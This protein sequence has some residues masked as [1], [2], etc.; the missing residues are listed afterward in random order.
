MGRIIGRQADC[1]SIPGNDANAEASHPPRKLRG[2]I[3]PRLEGNLIA[4]PAENL[5]DTARRLNQ[6]VSSQKPLSMGRN[7]SIRNPT[8]RDRLPK[9]PTLGRFR[10]P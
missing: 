3:L 4:T 5:V 7:R 10:V 6:V 8:S 9:I 1:H 2:H